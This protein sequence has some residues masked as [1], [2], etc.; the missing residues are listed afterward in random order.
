MDSLGRHIIIELYNC[1]QEKIDDVLVV[2]ETM[3]K[4]AVEAGA[5]L[6]NTTFHHFAP[7]GVSGVVVIQESHLSIHTW[8]EY[9]FASVDIFTCGE[10]VDPWRA[11]GIIQHAFAASHHSAVEMLRGQKSQLKKIDAQKYTH[12]NIPP[13]QVQVQ[14]QV[15]FTEKTN[16]Y[17]LSIKHKGDL[18]FKEHTAHQRIEVYHTENF[19]KMLVLDGVIVLTEK[20]GFVYHEMI[21]HIPL[22]AHDKPSDILILGGGDG[23]VATEVLKHRYIDKIDIFEID[24]AVPNV[25]KE[26]F[27]H[28][29]KAFE[30]GKVEV[31][32]EDILQKNLGTN[33]EKYDVIVDDLH[34]P[35]S[36]KQV[37]EQPYVHLK[38]ILEVMHQDS[39]LV[40]SVGSPH[41]DKQQ[42]KTNVE[43][44]QTLFG[45]ENV[46]CYLATIPTFPTGLWCFALCGSLPS[47]KLKTESKHL[48]EFVVQ[49][50][51]QY[52]TAQI[53]EAAFV[54][55]AYLKS[56]ID[57]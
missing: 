28:F 5:T 4:A 57:G 8:P 16:D 1:D 27:P 43:T 34:S 55:P 26:Q 7:F 51:F 32:F 38:F 35:L 33:A 31:F 36:T 23:A 39:L 17:A 52:Y 11:V 9:G 49:H 40:T 47:K 48:E 3:E 22:L 14:R 44:L 13:E 41:L 25:V 56:I 21:S 6:I 20:D 19:G 53:H 12:A 54:L 15:W 30:N 46:S 29:Y 10:S 2:Q 37:T 18:L 24:T 45:K 42:F 50:D